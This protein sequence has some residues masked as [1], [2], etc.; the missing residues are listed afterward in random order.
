MPIT[1]SIHKSFS[2]FLL[3]TIS[4][5][6]PGQKTDVYGIRSHT[7][8][9]IP[10]SSELKEIASS[11]PWGVQL[12]WSRLRNTS[13]SW[14][15]CNCYA[16]TGLSFNYFNYANPEQLGSSYN[17]IYFAEPYLS[18]KRKLF[19]SFRAGTGV[20]YLDQVYD[21]SANPE[22]T[23]YSSP[24]SFILLVSFN[25]NY[26]ISDNYLLSASAHYNHISNGGLEQP[27]K[28]MNFP[29]F[30]LGVSYMANAIELDNRGKTTTNKGKLYYY[31]RLFG[32]LPEVDESETTD[33]TRKLLIGVSGGALYHVTQ[34]NALN[35]G[36]EIISNGAHKTQAERMNED[37][38]HKSINLM[39]GHNFVFGKITFSQQ[40]GWYLYKPFPS[41][42][43]E[44]F[45]RY[46]LLYKI[47]DV[48]QVGTGLKAHGHVADNLDVRL[49][50]LLH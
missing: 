12:E 36:V 42:S 38:D 4:I 3:L 29:T 9:I 15:Q 39:V 28:G 2:V 17:L 25:V 50:V 32:T 34:S 35:L 43:K 31:T 41:T 23:F 7:G 26:R 48:F 1:N 33:N 45:Q 37:Y 30:G 11:T 18:Y 5:S 24:I 21:E 20:T 47:G 19:Y 16:Q 6:S 22:N 49:G 14:D 8:F 27:N 40:V 13:K 44:F 46:E 10:H